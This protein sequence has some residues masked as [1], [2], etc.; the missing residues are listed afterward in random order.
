MFTYNGYTPQLDEL[1]K[2]NISLFLEKQSLLTF[3][4]KVYYM[5]SVY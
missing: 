3:H 1:I 2:S 5:M 4:N